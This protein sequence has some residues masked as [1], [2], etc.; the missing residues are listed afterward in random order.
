MHKMRKAKR[1]RSGGGEVIREVKSRSESTPHSLHEVMHNKEGNISDLDDNRDCGSCGTHFTSAE[2]Y[3]YHRDV[4]LLNKTAKFVPVNKMH[5]KK[6]LLLC[7]K[8][9]C[10]YS[11]KT[12][13]SLK[14]GFFFIYLMLPK[15][16]LGG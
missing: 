11:T 12:K 2:A 7:S 15:Y 4:K 8:V 3:R 5:K 14:V 16:I 6:H 9:K 10:C 1:K 13:A